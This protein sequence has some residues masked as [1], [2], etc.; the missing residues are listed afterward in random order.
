MKRVWC[1]KRINKTIVAGILFIKKILTVGQ[2]NGIM[3][4]TNG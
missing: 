3:M 1:T 4:L 2:Q